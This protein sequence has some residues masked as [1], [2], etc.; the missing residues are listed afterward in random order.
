MLAVGQYNDNWH[1]SLCSL[2]HLFIHVLIHCTHSLPHF[3]LQ[4]W[5]FRKYGLLCKRWIRSSHCCLGPTHHTLAQT[6]SH[7][8]L[9]MT[10][11]PVCWHQH[12]QLDEEDRDCV[13]LR[14]EWG[15]RLKYVKAKLIWVQR[16][17]RTQVVGVMAALSTDWKVTQ[18]S[19]RPSMT[20]KVWQRRVWWDWVVH[21]RAVSFEKF[22]IIKRA[23]QKNT[24]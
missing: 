10:S 23:V 9:M 12:G 7:F 8:F 2:G 18:K 3:P 6:S 19:S 5:C 24:N 21:C 22:I 15:G 13:M 17:Q 14:A 11:K 4:Y 20:D 16:P 1:E